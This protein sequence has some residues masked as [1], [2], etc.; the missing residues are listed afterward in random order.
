MVSSKFCCLLRYDEIDCNDLSINFKYSSS[1][2][3]TSALLAIITSNTFLGFRKK[4][5]IKFEKWR[6]FIFNPGL[7]LVELY[8]S[9]F[10]NQGYCLKHQSDFQNVFLRYFDRPSYPGPPCATVLHWSEM[11]K[12]EI[13]N[14][15][16]EKFLGKIYKLLNCASSDW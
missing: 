4:P 14:M 3:N 11:K 12:F 9:N 16:T 6:N 10:L 8:V 1:S 5:W 7:Q 15:W 2:N 13:R